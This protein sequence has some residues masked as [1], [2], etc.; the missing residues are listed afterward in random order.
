MNR[1]IIFIIVFLCPV[2]IIADSYTNKMIT[3]HTVPEGAELY[4]N[5]K[6]IGQS[7][8]KV[9][10]QD[11][12]LAP[13]YIVRAEHDGY[14]NQLL[15]L[16]QRIK[17]G[18]AAGAVCCGLLWLPGF[19]IGIYATEHDEEYIVY[20]T[21]KDNELEAPMIDAYPS[22]NN[23]SDKPLFDPSTGERIK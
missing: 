11:G 8:S 20:L 17:P 22:S 18:L 1:N 3:I 7:P 13:K 5:G 15:K 9:R 12:M 4:L 23:N 6:Y 21:K 10:V 19:A 2:F 16:D 14:K